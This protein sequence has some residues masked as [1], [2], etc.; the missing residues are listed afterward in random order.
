[1]EKYIPQTINFPADLHRKMVKLA[2]EQ[3]RSLSG[4]VVFMLQQVLKEGGK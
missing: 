4:Q 2:K 1:M 3:N